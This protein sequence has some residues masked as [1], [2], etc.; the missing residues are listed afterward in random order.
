MEDIWVVL[1]LLVLAL[2]PATIAK[3]KGENFIGWYIYGVLLWIVALIHSIVM[4]D[5]SGRQCPMCKEWIKEEAIVCKHCNT[6][7]AEYY[8]NNP[9]NKNIASEFS[10]EKAGCIG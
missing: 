4:K 6:N 7:I 5:K 3:K 2:I 8:K 9:E 1:L 10:A